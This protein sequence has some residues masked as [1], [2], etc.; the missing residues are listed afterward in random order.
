M[1]RRGSVGRIVVAALL[2]LL[3]LGTPGVRAEVLGIPE[4]P[5][6]LRERLQTAVRNLDDEHP[7]IW[8]SAVREVMEFGWPVGIPGPGPAR[9]LP[10]GIHDV[11][12]WTETRPWNPWQSDLL[13]AVLRHPRPEVR[14]RGFWLVGPTVR[15]VNLATLTEPARSAFKAVVGE[16]LQSSDVGNRVLAAHALPSLLSRAELVPWLP[17]LLS[18]PADEV[19]RLGLDALLELPDSVDRA[20][21]KESVINA[22][23][24]PNDLVAVR[25]LAL[26]LTSDS[27]R[28]RALTAVDDRPDLWEGFPDLP[29]AVRDRA[30]KGLD[31][32]LPSLDRDT[33]EQV[34]DGVARAFEA[35]YDKEAYRHLALLLAEHGRSSPEVQEVLRVWAFDPTEALEARRQAAT[36]P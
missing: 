23:G 21:V 29:L 15:V 30:L 20:D 14:S 5:V 17:P 18:D 24:D 35:E 13:T 27:E 7:Q 16:A 22:L 12:I 8:Q 1:S 34:L 26:L 32:A 36:T 2:V 10:A 31:L 25:A 28:S 19:R 6:S 11:Q 9:T 3:C 4:Y 33:R